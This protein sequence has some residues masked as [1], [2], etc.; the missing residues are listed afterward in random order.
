[1]GLVLTILLGGCGGASD[2]ATDPPSATGT[3][4]SSGSSSADPSGPTDTTTGVAAGCESGTTVSTGAD[5]SDALLTATPGDV[6]LLEPGTYSGSFSTTASGTAQD[7]I[8]LCGTRDAILD[9]GDV[10]S[11]YTLHLDGAAHWL[12][13]G[14]TVTGGQKGVMLDSA[15]FNTLSDLAVG[16]TGDE[17]VHFRANSTDNLIENSTISDT[18][19][20]TPKYGEGV[21][22]GTAES[23][24]CDVT[25]CEP[26]HSDRNRIVG[27]TISRTSSESIDV[28]EGTSGGEI[29]GNTFDGAGLI[30][31]D[32]LL[33]IKGSNWTISANTGS[34]SPVDGAQ[35]HAI[36]EAPG[37]G[38]VFS[39]N[40]FSIGTDGYAINVVGDA[41]DLNNRV[42][43]SNSVVGGS[44]SRV[45]NEPC[46]A[47]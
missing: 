1:M 23:N 22:I 33:D 31:T 14:F 36:D 4:T 32:S 21:Y 2:P 9:G 45:S 3:G 20:R 17:A 8:V 29:S 6:I 42:L 13:Q 5:L 43:C 28:K 30:D 27:N 46:V 11:G 25:D 40:S 39:A 37:S 34:G 24:W 12:L 47:G 26:D 10:S 41:R 44:A 19:Q 16:N 15:T 7:P 35:V 18:G 38:N